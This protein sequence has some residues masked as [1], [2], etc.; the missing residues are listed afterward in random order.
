[1][2]AQLHPLLDTLAAQGDAATTGGWNI[3][4]LAGG[5]NNKPYR[6]TGELG[7]I[8][9]KFTRRDE[10]DRAGREYAA[11]RLL[12][13]RAPGLAPRPVLLD[14]ERYARPVVVQ[15]ARVRHGHNRDI[16]RQERAGVGGLVHSK[17]LVLGAEGVG[18]LSRAA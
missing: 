8:V 3:T 5:A 7:D 10:R 2:H 13:E 1:M 15:S 17:A 6:A 4:P 12:Q 16:E 18:L 11:L 14:R 9:V